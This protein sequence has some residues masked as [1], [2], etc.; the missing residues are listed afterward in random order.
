MSK[1]FDENLGSASNRRE[2]S[3]LKQKYQQY[4]PVY[5]AV[6]T[7]TT[8]PEFRELLE[9][10]WEQYEPYADTNFIKEF[11]KQFSQ[12]SWELY[13]GSTLLNR[14]LDLEKHSNIGPDLKIHSE[15][16]D[17]WI[18][19]ISVE[20][21]GGN[22]KVPDIENGVWTDVPEEKML[23][24]LASGL[25]E[26]YRK[27]E[28][29]VKNKVISPNDPFVIAIDRSS[30][31]HVDPQVPLIL[32]C[33]FAIGHQVLYLKR[34]KPVAQSEGSNWSARD[35]INKISGSNVEMLMFRD[36][37]FEGVSA[38]IY[39]DKN[40]LNSPRDRE[41]MGDNLTIAYNPFAKS[42]L[43]SNFFKF[44]ESWIQVGSQVKKI[45]SV[46]KSQNGRT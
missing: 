15:L 43:P 8:R 46:I 9:N 36:K 38:V 11:K 25:T 21:G 23:L 7:M 3:V 22:D 27:Y 10:I 33:L 14:G 4:D 41:K 12:R 18:E 24:R 2:L 28:T 39:S 19:A 31:E 6:S 32:K 37:T 20:K 34:N 30:L 5:V 45:S 13:L 29:Y 40:I 17:I 35:K 44:G 1:L 26:K 42:P 16:G